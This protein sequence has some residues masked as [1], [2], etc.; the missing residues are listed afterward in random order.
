MSFVKIKLKKKLL[1][2][3]LA[4]FVKAKKLFKF[5]QKNVFK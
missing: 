2:Y 1:K 5:R 3:Y 4:F